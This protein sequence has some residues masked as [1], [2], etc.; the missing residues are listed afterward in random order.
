MPDGAYYLAGYAIECALKACIAKLTNQHDYPDKHFALD[1]Y[2]HDIEKLLRLAGLETSRK[3]DSGVNPALALNWTIVKDWNERSRYE[4]HSLAKARK[5]I[6]AITDDVNGVL[7]WI[8]V[9]W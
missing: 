8:K 4:R 3:A 6:D 5:L 2:T 9:R 7:P 1:C